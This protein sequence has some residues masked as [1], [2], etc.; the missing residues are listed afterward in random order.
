MHWCLAVIFI[1]DKRIQYYDSMNGSGEIYLENLKQYLIDEMNHKKK[2]K[3]DWEGE[4]WSLRPTTK[5]TPQQHNGCDCGVFTTM[6]AEFISEDLPLDFN[7]S[8][9]ENFRRKIASSILHSND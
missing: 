9:M 6:F 7:Q 2:A 1:K 8:D 4:G 3:L 5:D